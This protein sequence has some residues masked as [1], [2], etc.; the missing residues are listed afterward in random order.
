VIDKEVAALLRL[1]DRHL[2]VEKGRVVWQGSST[3]LAADLAA[4]D[5]Y[6]SI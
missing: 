3:A 6:L 4:R 5:R 1:C 2:I